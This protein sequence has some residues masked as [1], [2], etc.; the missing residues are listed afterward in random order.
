MRTLLSPCQRPPT[1]VNIPKAIEPPIPPPVLA[2]PKENTEPQDISS[3]P[4]VKELY[5]KIEIL[6]QKNDKLQQLIAVKDK[7]IEALQSKLRT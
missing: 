7:K 5:K 1:P 2:D 4:A 6:T 3:H